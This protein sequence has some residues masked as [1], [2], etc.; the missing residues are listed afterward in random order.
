[1]QRT[2]CTNYLLSAVQ[3]LAEFTR[4]G[5]P[6]GLLRRQCSKMATTQGKYEWIRVRHGLRSEISTKSYK[7]L[8]KT[9][10]VWKGKYQTQRR[11]NLVAA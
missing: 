8:K 4:L 10:Q 5:Y 9:I 11:M 2:S 7:L 1:M 6:R 3:K